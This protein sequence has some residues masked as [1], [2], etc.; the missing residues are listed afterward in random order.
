M[1][2]YEDSP[3]VRM[4]YRWANIKPVKFNYSVPHD[5]SAGEAK[6]GEELIIANYDLDE[7]LGPLFVSLQSAE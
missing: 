4:V 1:L 3:T 6:M 5:G 2:T 7:V